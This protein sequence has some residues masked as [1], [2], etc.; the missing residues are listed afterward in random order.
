MLRGFVSS[1]GFRF[2]AAAT[3]VL[4]SRLVLSGSER[5]VPAEHLNAESPPA[6]CILP[7]R[8]L[9]SLRS[10]ELFHR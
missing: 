9:S 6:S 2:K 4:K 7:A 5:M 8:F 10:E 3:K 1:W